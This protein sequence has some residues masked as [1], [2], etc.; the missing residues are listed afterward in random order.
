[1]TT[2]K[3]SLL[4]MSFPKSWI[5]FSSFSFFPVKCFGTWPFKHFAT[6]L[7]FKIE[8]CKYCSMSCDWSMFSLSLCFSCRSTNMLWNYWLTG[9]KINV[10]SCGKRSWDLA[11]SSSERDWLL[12][13]SPSRKVWMSSVVKTVST[14]E[15]S[16]K[17]ACF[18][19][20]IASSISCLAFYFPFFPPFEPFYFPPC[21]ELFFYICGWLL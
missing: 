16:S 9:S 7:S 8:S 20:A 5:I 12:N 2:G 1:M 21:F 17:S 18:S 14:M 13:H 19:S 4:Q 11:S 15:E 3:H 6:R 10:V